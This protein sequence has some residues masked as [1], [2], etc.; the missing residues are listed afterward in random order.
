MLF[1]APRVE[2]LRGAAMAFG[3]LLMPFIRK[4]LIEGV[5]GSSVVDVLPGGGIEGQ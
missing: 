3:K 2:E 4:G 5:Y 1:E